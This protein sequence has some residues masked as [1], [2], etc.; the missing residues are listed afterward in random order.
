MLQFFSRVYYL[1]REMW[2]G[3]RR[4]GWMNWAA[5]STVTVLLFLFG[6]GLL[7]SWQIQGVVNQFGS[8]LEISVYLQPGVTFERVTGT[9][10]ALPSVASL[11][12]IPKQV[13]WEGL[14]KELGLADIEGATALLNGNPLVDELR[15]KAV[16][17]QVVTDLAEQLRRLAGV[18]TVQYGADAIAQLVQINQGIS[19]VSVIILIGLML[20]AIAAITTTIRLIVAARSTE[21]EIMQLVG[22]TRWWITLP[23]LLQGGVFGLVGGAI[24]WGFIYGVHRSLLQL[25]GNQVE[26]VQFL[27]QNSQGELALLLIIVMGFGLVIGLFGSWLAVRQSS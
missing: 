15:V 3:L 21:I 2:L 18:E 24:A 7:T 22:A 4:G 20:S 14:V 17:P 11:T 26:F 5:V 19:S 25:L 13:A 27:G 12:P 23:F 10:A 16:S 8:Q 9:I 1:W 6:L